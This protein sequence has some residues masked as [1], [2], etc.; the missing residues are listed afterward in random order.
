MVNEEVL[1]IR[2]SF[3]KMIQARNLLNDIA[4]SINI[5]LLLFKKL[6]VKTEWYYVLRQLDA[7]NFPK[8]SSVYN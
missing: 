1:T 3:Q 4:H 5:K 7:G 8:R 6:T 2:N